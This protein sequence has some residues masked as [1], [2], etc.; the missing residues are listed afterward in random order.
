MHKFSQFYTM[1]CIYARSFTEFKNM[2]YFFTHNFLLLSKPIDYDK[3]TFISRDLIILVPIFFIYKDLIVLYFDA[4][5]ED[6][7]ILTKKY[8]SNNSLEIS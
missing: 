3:K 7:W 2:K 6:K 5:K 1:L 4:L 8:C